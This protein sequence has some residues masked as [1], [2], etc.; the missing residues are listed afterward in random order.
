MF[1]YS[2]SEH[3]LLSEG[4]H[5]RSTPSSPCNLW[6]IRGIVKVTTCTG[7]KPVNQLSTFLKHLLLSSNPPEQKYKM[8]NEWVVMCHV[9]QQSRGHL[10]AMSWKKQF[11]WWHIW[12]LISCFF[13]DLV[14]F[15]ASW[16]IG[17]GI[18]STSATRT[19]VRSA[20]EC[21]EENQC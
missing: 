16:G 11:C 9:E 15:P 8:L 7:L 12:M 13:S 17:I 1:K 14:F 18:K 5:S 20:K 10:G 6:I 19:D 21:R 2:T 4:T 3:E